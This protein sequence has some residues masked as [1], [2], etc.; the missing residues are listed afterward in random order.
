MTESNK[1]KTVAGALIA[2]PETAPTGL[3]SLLEVFSS[4]GT[5]WEDLTGEPA[6]EVRIKVDIVTEHEGLQHCGLGVPVESHAT[7]RSAP[8]YDFL[9]VP[10]VHL[11]EDV[12]PEGQWPA[13]A[14]WVRSQFAGGAIVASACTGALLLAETGLLDNLE[15]TTHWGAVP[16][17]KR[18]FPQV[19]LRPNKILAMAGAEQRIITAGGASS[20]GELALY[21]IAFY[22]GRREA[23]RISKI[24][25]LGDLSEGQLPFAALTRPEAHNDA[26]IDKCQLWIAEHY[27]LAN[28]VERVTEYSG[29]NP[30][31]FKRRFFA[32]TGSTPIEYIQS[33]R[34]EEG[35]HLLET[36]DMPTDQVGMEV[37]YEDS[38]SFRRLFKRLTGVTPSRYRRRFQGIGRASA[39]ST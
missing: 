8:K 16:L 15:A 10:D 1:K 28:P 21:L 29:L 36:S 33:L 30:R 14:E 35:K 9:I 22:C 32:A 37:G 6:G 24:F 4:V 31:T 5:V 34:I 17:F 27:E 13:A 11:T 39:T 38:A 7:F 18:R 12:D 26:I 2:L 23:V 19:R 20:W 3:Y 25:L